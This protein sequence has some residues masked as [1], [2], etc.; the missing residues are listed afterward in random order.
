M[1]VRRVAAFDFDGT[2]TRRDTLVP[3]LLRTAGPWATL[4]GAAT[5]A[6]AWLAGGRDRNARRA[7]A[8][9][10][11]LRAV[12]AGTPIADLQERGHEYAAGLPDQFRPASLERIAW[13]R[14]EGHEL[15]LVTASLRLYAEPAAM[16]L[17]F[18]HVI[19]VDLDIDETGRATGAIVGVNVRGPEKA[20]RLRRHL[21][22]GP[23]ELWAY[24]DSDGDAE[25]LAMADHPTWVGRRADR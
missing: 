14:S 1:S 2:I 8:K 15:V 7:K 18:D 16:A 23:V 24:G 9:Q 21:G 10:A 4:R 17:G 19:A 5:G 22:D 6:V 13:H 3:F 20:T 11:Y 12:F 25:L